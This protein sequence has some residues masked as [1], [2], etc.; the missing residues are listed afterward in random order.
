MNGTIERIK[1]EGAIKA[2]KDRIRSLQFEITNSNWDG[3]ME[4]CHY[5]RM[6]DAIKDAETILLQMRDTLAAL[7]EMEP[8][9]R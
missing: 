7:S 8:E 4:G 6:G 5:I 3:T 1:H 2:L 9:N